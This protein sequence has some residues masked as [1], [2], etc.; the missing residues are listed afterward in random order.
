MRV[1]TGVGLRLRT[2]WFLL[3]SDYGV[4][5]DP[6]AGEPRSRMYFSIGQ[7]F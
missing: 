3:R 7:A 1:P 6:V 2:P 5:L 4:V